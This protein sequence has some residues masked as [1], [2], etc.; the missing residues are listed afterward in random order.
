MSTRFSAMPGLGPAA[1]ALLCWQKDPKPMMP[2][3]A[4]LDGTDAR[5]RADQL[6]RLKQGPQDNKSARPRGRPAGIG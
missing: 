4:K 5:W 3:S 1:E 2:R 6:A